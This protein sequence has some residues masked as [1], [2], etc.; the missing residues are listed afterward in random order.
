MMDIF[1][2][3][4]QEFRCSMNCQCGR[5]HNFSGNM[6][7]F[8]KDESNVYISIKKQICN[9]CRCLTNVSSEFLE[10]PPYLIIQNARKLDINPES[11]EKVIEVNGCFYELILATIF[12]NKYDGHYLG[13][14]KINDIFYLVDDLAPRK[15]GREIPIIPVFSSLYIKKL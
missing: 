10:D 4:A 13:V 14:F 12:T 15:C 2:N 8:V 3:E 6:I 7:C 5:M 11:L 9:S 1:I